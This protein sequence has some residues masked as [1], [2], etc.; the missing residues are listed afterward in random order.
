MATHLTLHPIRIPC[1]LSEE[2]RE[3]LLAPNCTLQILQR[4]FLPML[5][6]MVLISFPLLFF[7]VPLSKSIIL[8][9]TLSSLTIRHHH[10]L[11]S[12]TRIGRR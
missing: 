6:L 4:I 11:T 7:L 1:I 10:L 12:D 3:R 9:H 2:R 5:M 8:L